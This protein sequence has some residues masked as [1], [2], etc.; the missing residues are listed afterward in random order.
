MNFAASGDGS[1]KR[2]RGS[3]GCGWG[4]AGPLCLLGLGGQL[5]EMQ[6]FDCFGRAAV[7]VIVGGRLHVS[8]RTLPPL[9]VPPSFLFPPLLAVVS[10]GL[11]RSRDTRSAGEAADQ[12]RVVGGGADGGQMG[13]RGP[14]PEVG[15]GLAGCAARRQTERFAW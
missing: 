3:G 6:Q 5:W 14:V 11:C 8:C 4:W 13:R 12:G 9:S 2:V 7:I 1:R 10:G 15:G